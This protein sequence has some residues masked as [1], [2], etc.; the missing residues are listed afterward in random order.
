MLNTCSVSKE[1]NYNVSLYVSRRLLPPSLSTGNA[2]A[3]LKMLY[4][5]T[6]CVWENGK[7]ESLKLPF[8]PQTVEMGSHVFVLKIVS[9]EWLVCALDLL[10][11]PP[12]EWLTSNKACKLGSKFTYVRCV[13]DWVYCVKDNQLWRY[14]PNQEQILAQ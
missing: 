8:V 12:T 14:Q 11:K 9:G 6:L 13:G 10:N 2:L 5:R 7:S 3:Q 4:D 1:W